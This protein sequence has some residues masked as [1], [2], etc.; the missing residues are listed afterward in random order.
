MVT[1]S[2]QWL[3]NT[4]DESM[5]LPKKKNNHV[6]QSITTGVIGGFLASLCCITPLVIVLF[7]L[8]SLSTA[9]AISTAKFRLV[10]FSISMVFIIG[11][12][13]V[14]MMRKHH[15][16][17]SPAAIKQEWKYIITILITF[18]IVYTLI[19]YVIVPN[20]GKFFVFGGG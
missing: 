2:V 18:A 14:H 1:G 10:T 19:T 5:N 7:G 4:R 9:L 8:G 17:Y 13:T 15:C 6:K 3:E 20:L 11:A 12:I 16:C